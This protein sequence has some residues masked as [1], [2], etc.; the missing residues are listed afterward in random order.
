M[1]LETDGIGCKASAAWHRM[2]WYF[3]ILLL[4]DIFFTCFLCFGFFYLYLLYDD[5]MY[6]TILLKGGS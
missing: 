1:V 5:V 6:V 4:L 2:G 3:M